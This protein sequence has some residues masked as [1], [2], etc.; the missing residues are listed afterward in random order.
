MAQIIK[1]KRQ[2]TDPVATPT[3]GTVVLHAQCRW[4]GEPI[5]RTEA[6]FAHSEV[7]PWH[8]S[9]SQAEEC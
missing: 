8:H 1:I 6:D 9:K 3:L 7:V 5:E 4:C 2:P